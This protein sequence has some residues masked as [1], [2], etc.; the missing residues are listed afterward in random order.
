MGNA[1]SDFQFNIKAQAEMI[2]ADTKKYPIYK[3]ITSSNEG[4]LIKLAKRAVKT[5]DF[6]E[7]DSVIKNE[8]VEFLYNQGDGENVIDILQN[9]FIVYLEKLLKKFK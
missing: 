4:L 7:L 3:Y 1:K 8:V 2:N 9:Y 6:T 5:K